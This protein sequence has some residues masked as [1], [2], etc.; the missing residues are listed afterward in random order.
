MGLRIR[1]WGS[2]HE[3]LEHGLGARDLLV[4]AFDDTLI[5]RFGL[6]RGLLFLALSGSFVGAVGRALAA[7]DLSDT[8]ESAPYI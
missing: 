5:E 1:C 4:A 7:V 8:L 3:D 2:Q 6:R